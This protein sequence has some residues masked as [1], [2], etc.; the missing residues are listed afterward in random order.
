MAQAYRSVVGQAAH[1]DPMPWPT[2]EQL[3]EETVDTWLYW[4]N[5]RHVLADISNLTYA[6][7]GRGASNKTQA[8]I[9]YK[10]G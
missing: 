6:R 7:K 1:D 2:N 5:I 4:K 9:Q 10:N 3:P 8:W